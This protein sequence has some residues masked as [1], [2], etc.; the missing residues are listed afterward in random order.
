MLEGAD[1][2]LQ[3]FLRLLKTEPP[4]AARI[5]AVEVRAGGLL[6][7]QEFRHQS[8]ANGRPPDG[9]YFARPAGMRGLLAGARGSARPPLSVSLHQLHQLRSA[10][11]RHPR[12]ALRPAEHH[13][14]GLAAGRVLRRASTTIPPTAGSTRSR[15]PAPRAARIILCKHGAHDVMAMSRSSAATVE[16]LRRRQDRRGEGTR[17]ISPG[18]RRTQSRRPCMRCASGKY[19]KEKP[20]AVMVQDVAAARALVELSPR[21]R[22]CSRRLRGRSCW[23]RQELKLAGGR[24]GQSTNSG[25]CCPIRRCIICSSPRALRRCW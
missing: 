22:R 20:F 25:S 17:R 1:P 21:R 16:L 14:E 13:H 3:E 6:G 15:S 18:L 12:A 8:R 19:R 2:A 9:A 5:T 24:P 7:F 11:H 23:R 4:P 10:L